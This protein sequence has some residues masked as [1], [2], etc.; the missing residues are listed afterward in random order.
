MKEEAENGVHEL[1]FR[2]FNEVDGE[3]QELVPPPNW[4]KAH[5]AREIEAA[6]GLARH[7]PALLACFADLR[8]G[9]TDKN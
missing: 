8:A 7:V 9:S 1:G 2:I 6:A 3:E 5:M 4:L